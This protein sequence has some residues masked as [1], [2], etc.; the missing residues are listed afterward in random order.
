MV[1]SNTATFLL[2]LSEVLKFST[3]EQRRTW[4][5][6]IV[7]NQYPLHE[8]V[9]LLKKDTRTAHHFLWLLSD[10]GIKEPNYLH[11]FLPWL[12]DHLKTLPDNYRMAMASYWHLV[13]VPEENEGE[14]IDCLFNW[15]SSN[16]VNSSIKSRALW[17]LVKLAKKHPAI[18]TE[19][20]VCLET[21]TDQHTPDFQKR[22]FKLQKE[23]RK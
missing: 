13:G 12:L 7:A 15:I 19:V 16:K 11:A 23:L 8:L 21:L 14:A 6:T 10:V 22:I 2:H 20:L 18:K 9:V 17:V 1:Q 4:A 5:E 3:G